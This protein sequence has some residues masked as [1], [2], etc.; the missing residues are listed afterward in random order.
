VDKFEFETADPTRRAWAIR[1][2]AAGKQKGAAGE[3][4]APF[5]VMR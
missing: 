5:E 4:A 3:P 2:S 1:Q